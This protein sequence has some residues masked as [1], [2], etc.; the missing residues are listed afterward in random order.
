MIEIDSHYM[1]AMRIIARTDS[2]ILVEF[3]GQ[4]ICTTL[5]TDL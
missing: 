4:Q 3:A 1:D 2:V 5:L